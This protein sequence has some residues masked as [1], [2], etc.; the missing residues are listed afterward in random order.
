MKAFIK[1]L[2]ISVVG[3]A[4]IVGVLY[5]DDIY[6]LFGIPL[7]ASYAICLISDILG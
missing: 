1:H 4:A 3:A 5:S 7:I 6:G 2:L